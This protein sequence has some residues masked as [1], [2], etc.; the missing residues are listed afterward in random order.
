M[1]TIVPSESGSGKELAANGASNHM[2]EEISHSGDQVTLANDNVKQQ[3]T[4]P[5]E[6][7]H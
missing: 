4:I 6:F 7:L 3:L 2:M 1:D 5:G